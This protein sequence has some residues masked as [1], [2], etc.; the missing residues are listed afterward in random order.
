MSSLTKSRTRFN[1]LVDLVNAKI[2]AACATVDRCVYVDSETQVDQLGG[3]M[4]EPGIN[5]KYYGGVNSPFD[6]WN[7]EKTIFYEW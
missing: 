4:C 7:R 2:Q 5:E 3:R 6:G 1:D